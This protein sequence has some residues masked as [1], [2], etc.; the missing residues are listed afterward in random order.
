M[1]E[2]RDNWHYAQEGVS[3]DE[4]SHKTRNSALQLDPKAVCLCVEN[5][6]HIVTSNTDYQ[7]QLRKKELMDE[8]MR[9]ALEQNPDIASQL[10]EIQSDEQ[11]VWE[12][13]RQ[14][15]I[16]AYHRWKDA[17]DEKR[18]SERH[19]RYDDKRNINAL[20]GLRRSFL[21]Q[22]QPRMGKIQMELDRY[23]SKYGIEPPKE[24][25]DEL[26]KLKHAKELYLKR[27]KRD[28]EGRVIRQ[29]YAG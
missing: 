3:G 13:Q 27:V 25:L 18:R 19:I 14:M 2:T 20:L 4:F 11:R 15:D 28:A 22:S 12:N 16:E 7:L 6:R 24:L 29:R 10:S 21:Y 1:F 17:Q 26:A 5:A 9:R 8:L 23:Y